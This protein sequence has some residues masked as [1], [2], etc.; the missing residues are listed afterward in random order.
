[1]K[2]LALNI[3]ILLLFSLYAHPQSAKINNY[4]QLVAEGKV[5]RVKNRL[6]E[7]IN[8][9]GEEP[10]VL[11]LQG[12][13]QENAQNSIPYFKKILEKFPNSE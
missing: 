8:E 9:Y 10:G 13:I 11:L 4:L 2:I 7:L 1:M 6:P 5:E 12:V 3:V